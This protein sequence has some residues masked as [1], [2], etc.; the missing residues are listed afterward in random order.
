MDNGGT[1]QP[2]KAEYPL[3]MSVNCNFPGSTTTKLKISRIGH[4]DTCQ[5][6]NFQ[7]DV[8]E[9]ADRKVESKVF[10]VF[11]SNSYQFSRI[12]NITYDQTKISNTWTD[13]E[14]LILQNDKSI[15]QGRK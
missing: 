1:P 9:K 7:N 11:Y 8:R 6:F 4:L 12:Y 13:V 5:K 10:Y 2:T 14:K 15:S 3:L